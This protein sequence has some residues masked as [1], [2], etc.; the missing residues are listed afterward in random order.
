[1][2]PFN[3]RRVWVLA[4]VLAAA[5]SVL[6]A[7][8]RPSEFEG[9]VLPGLTFT[10]GVTFSSMWDSNVALAGRPATGSTADDMLF[11]VA[12]YA[13]LD[14]NTSRTNATAGY[15]G[16]IRRYADID[17]LNGYDQRAYASIRHR[18]TPRVTLFG[19]NEFSEMPTTDL[20]ELN[21]LPFARIGSRSNRASGGLDARLSQYLDFR[22]RYDNTWSS[23]DT[24]NDLVND[25]TINGVSVDLR[26]RLSTRVTVGGEARVRRSSITSELATADPEVITSRNRI[27][28]FQDMG[29]LLDYRLTEFTTVALAGGLTRLQDS[30][31]DE[32]R[33]DPYFRAELRHQRER[34][35][36]GVAFERTYTPSFGLSGSN[37]NRELRGFVTVPF[38]RNRF[39]LNASGIWRRS[40]PFFANEILLD[41][42]VT[43]TSIGYSALRWFR[44]EGYHGYSRQDSVITGGEV[45]RHR[46]G[47]QVVVSQPMRIR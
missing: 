46:L 6:F 43:N 33:A 14:L 1:M 9:W 38:S 47:V 19:Q 8:E 24:R 31:F 35:T 36:M 17:S 39:Y 44:V 34:A 15:R 12:P 28:W 29:G 42:Y 11:Q 41:T 27:I 2:Q 40:E 5:P 20:I 22:V 32:S 30:R 16:Y 7:Q 18:L 4:A 37:N 23:F 13:Q 3:R 10:P 25:G 21:G 26:R 45:S